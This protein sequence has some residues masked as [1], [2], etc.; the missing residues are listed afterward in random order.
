MKTLALCQKED[1][2]LL[3]NTFSLALLTEMMI[4]NGLI[5]CKSEGSERVL[6][7]LVIHYSCGNKQF[8]TRDCQSPLM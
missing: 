3:L 2:L 6:I 5:V 7:K 4:Q 1:W 8:S